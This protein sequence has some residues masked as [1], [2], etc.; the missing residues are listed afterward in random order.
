MTKQEISLVIDGNYLIFQSFYASY[1]GDLTN[2]LRNDEGFPTNA[3]QLFL[4]QMIKLI[5]HI[6]PKYL[7][8]AFDAPGKTKRHL[9]YSK[10][11][12]GRASSPNELYLQIDKIKE[13]LSVLKLPWFQQFGD[14]ADDLVATYVT[15]IPGKKFIFSADKDLLQLV[16]SD[17][18]VIL[19]KKNEYLHINEQNF[20]EFYHIKPNQIAT[21]K[22]LKGDP[23]DNLPGVCGIGDITAIKLIKAFNDF[24]NI[25]KN[26]ENSNLF[27]KSIKEKLLAG[28][29]DGKMCYELAKLNT[30][31]SDF[32]LNIQ[33]YL[34][35]IDLEAAND[36]LDQ[37]QLNTVKSWLIKLK[38]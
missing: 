37:L 8:I 21:Y 5:K 3:L 19:N 14:E 22:G 7:F 13:I 2:I 35:N 11:K 12:S 23:S 32:D 38:K 25:Y 17:V 29:S 30:D 31:V 4:M 20:V 1:R 26:I 15:K 9:Q 18:E 6:K 16:S 27:T 28:Y 33:K 10:Y 34:L 36:V 24:D